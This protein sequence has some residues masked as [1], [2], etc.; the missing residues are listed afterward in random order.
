MFF[1]VRFDDENPST[2]GF[3]IVKFDIKIDQKYN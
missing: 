3:M 2:V 1:G